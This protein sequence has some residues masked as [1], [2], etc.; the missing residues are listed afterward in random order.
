MK[1]T[2]MESDC[3]NH[4]LKAV[5]EDEAYEL[6]GGFLLAEVRSF[7][8]DIEQGLSQLL[9]GSRESYSF[10]G[11][12]YSLSA[13]PSMALVTDEIAFADSSLSVSTRE[14]LELVS[15]Y[16]AENNRWKQSLSPDEGGE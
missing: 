11:N 12:I 15:S 3:K 9:E 10:N 4:V 2:F 6:L 14:L 16:R 7:G 13:D 8:S 1:Y 5:F